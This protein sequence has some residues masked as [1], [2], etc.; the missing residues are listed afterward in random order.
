MAYCRSSVVTKTTA[1]ARHA[2][3]PHERME[4]L[5]RRVGLG[6][7]PPVAVTPLQEL[8]R[9]LLLLGVKAVE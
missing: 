5:A 1:A 9:F 8:A 7:V 3:P 2:G 6:R 4:N